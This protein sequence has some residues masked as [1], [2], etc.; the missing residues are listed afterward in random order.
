L[1]VVVVVLVVSEAIQKMSKTTSV[2][3]AGVPEAGGTDRE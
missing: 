3:P 1:L 2:L